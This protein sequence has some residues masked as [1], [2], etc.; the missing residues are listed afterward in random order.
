M[1]DLR[2]AEEHRL[3]VNGRDTRY[4]EAGSGRALVWLHAFPLS[5]DQWRPQ[6]R[7]TPDGWRAI[8]PDLRGFGPAAVSQREAI[9]IDDYAADVVA[10]L[11]AL[12]IETATVAGLSMGGYVAFAMFRQVP[13]RVAG[14]VL[15]DTKAPADTEEARA[16]RRANLELLRTK[17]VSAVIDALLPKLL[18]ETTK[19]EHPEIVAEVRQ[20]MA[21]TE[22]AGIERALHALMARP[23]S[24]PD[25]ARI[26]CPALVI[27]GE[28]D[29]LTPP[30]DAR[31]LS[32]AIRGAELTVIPGT[33]HLSNLEAADAFTDAVVAFLSR[34]F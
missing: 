34:A 2:M 8:A 23:D 30:S 9:G 24:T 12:G 19:R 32:S 16:G 31:Q 28:E 25:L 33:G 1:Y 14:I 10:L 27:V 26:A 13:E 4:L 22:P 3:V 15:A 17:G 6:L 5:A 7:A 29:A 11:D 18:G 21:V 20:L